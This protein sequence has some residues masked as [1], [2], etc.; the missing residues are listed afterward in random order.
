MDNHQP[1]MYRPRSHDEL[2]D[3][4]ASH[5]EDAKLVAG[6]TAFTILRR[7]GLLRPD[8]VISLSAVP[9]LDGIV[10]VDAG[11]R[12]GALSRLTS[13]ERS[14]M[15]RRHHP[16]LAATV[17]LVANRRVRNVATMGGNVSEA[18]PTSDPPGVLSAL[19]AVMHLTSRAGARAVPA[20]EFFVDYFETALREDEMVS[21]V[22]V[23][24]LGPSW[25]G[26][27]LKF[28]S[29]SAEDRTCIGVAAFVDLDGDECRGL[30]L[31]LVGMG[32]V[33]L[34]VPEAEQAAVGCR[35]ETEVVDR[36]AHAYVDASDPVSDIRGSADYRQTVASALIHDAISRAAQGVDDAVFA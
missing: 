6:G 1:L 14:S 23:P 22:E 8:H 27:Y 2:L 11:T 32:P 4:L 19:S 28:L 13:V 17:G 29:R 35:L 16:V 24:D 33:P 12:I 9:D 26:T 36:L 5:G 21:H 34:R 3:L 25:S 20:E 18:D 15:V 10:R 30:R 7:S 31:A